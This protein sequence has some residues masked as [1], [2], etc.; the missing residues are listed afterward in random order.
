MATYT[1]E[2]TSDGTC[3]SD[4]TFVIILPKK[5]IF[6]FFQPKVVV[7][8]IF[9]ILILILFI[10]VTFCQFCGNDQFRGHFL[11]FLSSF[12]CLCINSGNFFES[13]HRHV[14]DCK[15]SLRGVT[16]GSF[17][18]F[19]KFSFLA[20]FWRFLSRYHLRYLPKKCSRHKIVVCVQ[21]IFCQKSIFPKN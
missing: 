9:F 10:F 11:V 13:M 3:T 7:M 15:W 14:Y 17:L 1:G 16:L 8:Y 4:G 6:T 21:K 19:S 20:I 2:S 12:V 5:F 18:N